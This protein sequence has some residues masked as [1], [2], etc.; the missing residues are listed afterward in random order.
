MAKRA[1]TREPGLSYNLCISDHPLRY[2][3]H[4]GKARR[5][6]AAYRE[7]LT[8]LGLE[9]I[10]LAREDKLPDSCFVEDTAIIEKNKVFITRMAK[11]GRR[12]EELAIIEAL[13]DHLQ[14]NQANEPA[15]IEGGDVIHLEDQLIAGITERTN[16]D[17]IKQMMEWLAVPVTTLEA[18][19]VMH[20]K[21]YVTF[22]GKNTIIVT[23]KFAQHPVLEKFEKIIVPKFETYAANTLTINNVVLM[24]SNHLK[25]VGL[26][27]EAG[28][29]VITLDMSEFEK[30]GGA[31]TCLSLIF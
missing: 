21:S 10:L 22:L 29:E 8:S 18:L 30:C 19:E 2:D 27:R 25:S 15:T 3:V 13:K 6:H 20:L 4:I 12:G 24:S 5:Q 17:G 28:F 16:A 23:E 31:L 14:I 26:V 7:V 1:L 11:E 9:V